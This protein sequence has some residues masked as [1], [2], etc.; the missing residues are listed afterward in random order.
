M[1]KLS[2][3]SLSFCRS[4]GTSIPIYEDS[5]RDMMLDQQ[6]HIPNLDS[7]PWQIL[8]ARAE[9]NKENTTLPSKWASNKVKHTF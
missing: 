7:K 3:D 2:C 4:Q 9:R 6:S 1:S 8:G 5:G